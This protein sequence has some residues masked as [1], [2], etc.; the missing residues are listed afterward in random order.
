[1]KKEIPF[2]LDLLENKNLNLRDIL[3]YGYIKSYTFANKVCFC[4]NKFL[5]DKFK[6]KKN[7]IVVSLNRLKKENLIKIEKINNKRI[8]TV[9]KEVIKITQAGDK[10]HSNDSEKS[11]AVC[12]NLIDKNDSEKSPYSNSSFNSSLKEKEINK[13]KEIFLNY[14]GMRI[15]KNFVDKIYNKFAKENKNEY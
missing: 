12:N 9:C 10:N 3:I 11:P 2:Y 15:E 4:K 1:M 5:A 7:T 6:I 13:E 14:K 8:I